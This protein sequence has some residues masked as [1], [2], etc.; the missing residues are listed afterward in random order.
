MQRQ[1]FLDLKERDRWPEL[2]RHGSGGSSRYLQPDILTRAH[3]STHPELTLERRLSSM[4]QV[5]RR[6]SLEERSKVGA[7]KVGV[8]ESK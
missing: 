8:R 3:P 2:E 7:L 5:R 4:L 6:V 1:V